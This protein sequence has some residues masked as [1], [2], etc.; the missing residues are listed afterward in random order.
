MAQQVLI[1]EAKREGYAIDQIDET[2]TVAEMIAALERLDGDA[3]LYLSHD[4]GYTYGGITGWNMDVKYIVE[5]PE[6]GEQ[7]IIGEEDDGE[8]SCGEYLYHLI[9]Q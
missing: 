4:N 7:L 2:I 6:C 3:P 1:I 8:C 5:C 9:E